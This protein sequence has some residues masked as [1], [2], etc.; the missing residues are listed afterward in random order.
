MELTSRLNEKGGGSSPRPF[1]PRLEIT[2]S[3]PAGQ[4]NS[5]DEA[6]EP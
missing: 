3:E 1:D 6:V 2:M 5:D 4:D